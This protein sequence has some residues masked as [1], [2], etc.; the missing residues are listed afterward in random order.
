MK[1]F[2]VCLITMILTAIYLSATVGISN[3]L[4]SYQ[5]NGSLI[6]QN[7][8]TLGSKLI[9]QNFT[10]KRFF[11]GRISQNNY[12][13]DLS[14]NSNYPYYSMELI[15][16]INRNLLEFKKV[17]KNGFPS[18]NLITESASGL[19]PDIT[20]AG[21]LNQLERI[22]YSGR[23]KKNQIIQIIDFKARPRIL[24]LFGEKIVNVLELNIELQKLYAKAT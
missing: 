1:E 22:S 2:R 24:G 11:Q 19:D 17:N 23:L 12:K 7:K 4:F 3:L 8:I 9:G 13:N 21:A 5:A 10:N 14:G 15:S 18:L 16:S 6:K 20:Y